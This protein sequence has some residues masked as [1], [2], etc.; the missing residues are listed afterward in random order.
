MRRLFQ[1]GQATRWTALLAF[2][3]AVAVAVSGCGSSG[4]GGGATPVATGNPY[5][6][7][8]LKLTNGAPNGGINP[9]SPIITAYEKLHPQVKIQLT[10][11]PDATYGQVLQTQLQAGNGPDIFWATT[12]SGNISAMLSFAKGGYVLPMNQY[13]WAVT[14]VPSNAKGLF[15]QNGKQYGVP[16]DMVPVGLVYNL[17]AMSK[18]GISGPPSTMPALYADCATAHAAGKSFMNLAGAAADNTGLFAM[19]IAASSVYSSTPDWNTLRSDGKVTFAGTPQWQNALNTISTMN[20]KGCFQPGVAGGTLTTLFPAV[21]SG[22]ALALACPA[23]CATDLHAL[24]ASN[25][26]KVA[27]FPGQTAA[28]TRIFNSPTDALAVNAHSSHIAAAVAFLKYM[29]EPAVANQYATLSGNASMTTVT[30]GQYPAE[31]S[32]ITPYLKD[33]T[34]YYPLAN[35]FWPAAGV[36]TAL[37]NG[38]Q[39][40]LTKQA[41]TTQV[42][43]SMDSAWTSG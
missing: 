17:T 19:M 37:Q 22:S 30:T 25:A 43:Q 26:F 40:L 27:P 16:I 1:P 2:L 29:S 32:Y 7:V 35:L 3:A 13:P 33:Q 41:S 23:G 14:S 12:G 11:V 39:G 42:L 5:A 34:K 18:L 8:T 10:Q 6:A 24:G 15:Y 31:F 9:M 36:Y 21:A 20:A 38:I 28:Q 4:G